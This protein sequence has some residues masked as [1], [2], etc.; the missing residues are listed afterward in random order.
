MLFTVGYVTVL[1]SGRSATLVLALIAPD[2]L[3]IRDP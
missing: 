3:K 1:V 2:R